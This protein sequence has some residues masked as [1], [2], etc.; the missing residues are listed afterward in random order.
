[1][2]MGKDKGVVLRQGG[3]RTKLEEEEKLPSASKEEKGKEKEG[4]T[5]IWGS[6]DQL[7]GISVKR[8]T[9]LH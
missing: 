2:C 1:M 5:F 3:E 7:E 9:M 6:I 8:L 4:G